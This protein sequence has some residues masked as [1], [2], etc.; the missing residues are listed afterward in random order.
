MKNSNKIIKGILCLILNFVLIFGTYYSTSSALST[1]NTSTEQNSMPTITRSGDYIYYGIYNK[2]YKVNVKTKKKTLVYKYSKEYTNIY[3][4]SIYNGYIYFV[5]DKF[6]GTGG[7]LPYIYRIKT[8]GTSLKCLAKGENPIVYS[9]KIYY[10]KINFDPKD[11]YSYTPKGIYKMN[12]TGTSK[13]CV[14]SSSNI[15]NIKIYKSYIYYSYYSNSANHNY[16][17]RISTSGKNNSRLFSY[18]VNL[19]DVNSG[20]VYFNVYKT[21]TYNNSIYKYNISSKKTTLLKNCQGDI[22]CVK[23]G[24]LYYV[25]RNSNKNKDYLYKINLSTNKKTAITSKKYISYIIVEG[26]YIY[27]VGYPGTDDYARSYLIKTNGTDE[28]TLAKYF[29]P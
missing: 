23:N 15:N 22:Q 5:L 24:S 26:D 1:N 17:Y 27:Y 4:I 18:S 10:I 28:T 21:N 6:E 8:N 29:I 2:L 19:F 9:G 11:E 13:T 25:Y 20:Y 14:K 12:L 7:S 3:N 16:I